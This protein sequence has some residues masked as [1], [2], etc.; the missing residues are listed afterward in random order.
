MAQQKELAGT[1]RHPTAAEASQR[2]MWDVGLKCVLV[3]ARYDQSD[4]VRR[5][6]YHRYG[7][8][9]T[10]PAFAHSKGKAQH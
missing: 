2:R 7:V 9:L 1:P 4:R 8:A 6:A 5:L 10:Q 3:L